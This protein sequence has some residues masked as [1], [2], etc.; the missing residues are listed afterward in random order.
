MSTAQSPTSPA[1]RIVPQELAERPQWVVW[2]SKPA[3]KPDQKPRKLPIDPKTRK[4]AA[5]DDP[6]T[7]VSSATAKVE[8]TRGGYEG[9]MFALSADDPY[10]VIDL[11]HCRDAETG[12]IAEWAQA[13]I[14]RFNS[15]T[16][17]SPSGEGVHI[18]I[19]AAMPGNDHKG[20]K[21]GDIEAYSCGRF[22][23][24]TARRIPGT[25]E[26]IEERQDELEAFVADRTYF[27][28]RP[29]LVSLQS[30]AVGG[31]VGHSDAEILARAMRAR[32]GQDFS[33][34][35]AG[36]WKAQGY[37]SQSEADLALCG[38]LAFWTN[39]DA[40]QMDRLFRQSG[41]MREK[42]DE[43]R[44]DS[45]YG[46][47]TISRALSSP[48]NASA[49][50]VPLGGA[51]STSV[52]RTTVQDVTH[53]ALPIVDADG[54]PARSKD[55]SERRFQLLTIEE[56][57]SQ[58]HIRP[59]EL[60]PGKIMKRSLTLTYG[61][62]QTG[63][64]YY[65]QDTCF[66]LAA[67]GVPVWYVAAEGFD[68]MYLRIVAWLAKHPGVQLDALR[69]IPTPVNIF[70][71]GDRFALAHQ[72]K[73]LP[74]D[75]WPSLIVLDTLHRCTVG[76]RE[77]DNGDMGCVADAAA[78]WR[79]ELGAATWAIHHEGK[80]AGSG[81]RGASCLFDDADS[82]QYVFRGGDVSVIE[83][84]KQKDAI[85]LFAPEAYTL[86]S[87]SLDEHGFPGLSASVIERLPGEHII[88]ARRLWQADQ[89]RRL[90]GAKNAPG[91][92]DSK[93]H[94]SKSLELALGIFQ[95]L[96]AEYPDG[97][98]KSRWR[99]ACEERDIKPGSFDWITKELERRG[100]VYV[101][102]TTGRYHPHK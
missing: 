19:R 36:S 83:C 101:P 28:E 46:E 16:E 57:K 59:E 91:G 100:E 74:Q 1:C 2:K 98:F 95:E 78:L 68:G 18:W 92:E 42:W 89:Q 27:P 41:L 102:D 26:T 24:V 38:K 17:G 75:E 96:Y 72:A 21:H 51:T 12:A 53:R 4:A 93:K 31:E 23:T 80:S 85:P 55:E 15:Y 90:P 71:G 82:V 94:L 63:K 43:R 33:A 61:D 22:M 7:W 58:G 49:S 11:D 14:D 67:S 34:L 39:G 35:W 10:A 30:R 29:T 56:L 84:E 97:V 88:E 40:T 99:T 70:K 32:D 81:M 69:I 86:Q 44:A 77:S 8:Y 79:G 3:E 52:S 65:A 73:A 76:A 37:T 87:L 9:L 13:I 5:S 25:P 20:R 54:A 48:R 50:P 66:R 45:S 47:W 6:S 60:I 62:G 64:S